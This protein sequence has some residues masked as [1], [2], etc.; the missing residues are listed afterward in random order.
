M[1]AWHWTRANFD[2]LQFD[3]DAYEC[4]KEG[5]FLDPCSNPPHFTWSTD[6][7]P[8]MRKACLEERGYYLVPYPQTSSPSP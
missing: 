7:N 4:M 3:K 5:R 8:F 1:L 2:K 6:L